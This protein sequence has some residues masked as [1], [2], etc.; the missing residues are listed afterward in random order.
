MSLFIGEKAIW[1]KGYATEAI[2]LAS[3]YA[4]NGLNL[5]KLSAGFYA[6]NIGSI[7]AFQKNGFIQEGLRKNHRI[8]QG[9]YVDEVLMGKA[10]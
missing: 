3:E 2:A 6:A 5:H 7:K 1:G 10:R 4:F 9:A 8:Y